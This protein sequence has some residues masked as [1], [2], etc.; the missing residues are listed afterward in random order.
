MGQRAFKT[1]GNKNVIHS[2]LGIGAIVEVSISAAGFL[3][4]TVPATV[5]P[6]EVYLATRDA[7]SFLLS[8][9]SVGTTY[10]TLPA[11]T[12]F[13]FKIAAEPTDVICYIQGT[14]TTVLEA[15]MLV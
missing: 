2:Y 1:D 3:A 4:V 14:T 8:N 5:Y 6:K 15:M 10:I 12:F 7:A 9:V 11:D 13:R